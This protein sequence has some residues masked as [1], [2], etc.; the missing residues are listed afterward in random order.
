MII[1]HYFYPLEQK[2]AIRYWHLVLRTHDRLG[3]FKKIIGE[4]QPSAGS[5]EYLFYMSHQVSISSTFYVQIFSTN[6]V[7]LV[8]FWLCQKIR[9]KNLHV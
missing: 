8:T 4:R 2:R 7:F 9:T 1:E 5:T 6:I 3:C